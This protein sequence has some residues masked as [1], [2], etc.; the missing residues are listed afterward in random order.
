MKLLILTLT[1]IISI[2]TTN[3][4]TDDIQNIRK[5]YNDIKTK[6]ETDSENGVIEI[7]QVNFSRMMAAVGLCNTE[8]NFYG[9]EKIPM[10]EEYLG[11]QVDGERVL[12]FI[13][14]HYN[15]AAPE[16]YIEYLFDPDSQQLIFF[17]SKDETSS[18]EYRYYYKDDKLIKLITN[19]IPADDVETNK[20]EKTENFNKVELDLADKAVKKAKEYKT[21]YSQ[22][23]ALEKLEKIIRN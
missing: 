17:Y 13:T 23:Y 11:W 4:Q 7:N 14:V 16:I 3:A 12:Q 6:I 9:Y 1:I 2:C 18:K 20:K 22:L 15:I 10:E 21:M 5:I 8:V 19:S